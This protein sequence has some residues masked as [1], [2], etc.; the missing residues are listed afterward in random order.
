MQI[1]PLS[2]RIVVEPIASSTQTAS[3]LYIPENAQDKSQE[4]IVVALGEGRWSEFHGVFN[5]SPVHLGDRVL[6]AKFAGVEI[7]LDGKKHMLLNEREVLA[8]LESKTA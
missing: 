4:G 6:F 7:V 8:I 2:D 3:G 5:P 1:K